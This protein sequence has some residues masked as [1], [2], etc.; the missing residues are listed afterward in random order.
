MGTMPVG[1]LILTMSLPMIVSMLVQAMY[2]VV[3][4][5]F[6]AKL[7]QDA[8]SAVSMVFPIQNLMIAFSVGMG[9]GVNALLSRSLG[10]G[11]RKKVSSAAMQGILIFVVMC[12]IFVVT[13][14]FF[15]DPFMRS[16]TDIETI[17]DYGKTYMSIVCVASFGCFGQVFCEKVLQATGKTFHSMIVQGVGAVINLILDPIMIFG[18]TLP[19]IGPIL[20]F[21]PM[22]VAGAAWA[23]VIG[24][25]ASALLGVFINLK[26]NREIS[27]TVSGLKPDINTI[28]AILSV[29]IPSG[30]MGS[31]GSVMT[32][33]MNRILITFSS[34]C[35]S[36][37]GAYFKLQSFVFM[38]VFGLN[39]G[40][41]PIIAYNYGARRPDRMKKT[42]RISM[43][44]AVIGM[45]VGLIIFQ[46]IPDK[47]LGLFDAD[48]AML[49]VGVPA[50]RTISLA[51][52]FAGFCIVIISVFQA[53]G[54]GMM[55]VCVSLVRQIVVLL[56]SAYLFSL[57][58][59][60]DLVW[61]SFPIAEFVS[62]V[63]CLIF[64][65]RVKRLHMSGEPQAAT[66]SDKE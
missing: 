42:I 59:N 11:D 17:V 61:L 58:R 1:R 36:V 26:Y 21:E 31:I 39:N 40:M 2:N 18:N 12:A 66:S 56:P 9:V 64:F 29:G 27:F 52:L 22:G 30:V 23:T 51:W 53:L 7:S 37:F 28:K 50:L 48:E 45:M 13:G 34:A 55:S 15:S 63:M 8:L 35:V 3:D 16:Q 10:Q 47:L 65:A 43:T 14:L 4:S 41:V 32:Y 20:G 6:V 5:I 57:T 46:L 60:V 33:G 38:P 54:H 44:A 25:I 19:V 24:Q 49:A 62:V